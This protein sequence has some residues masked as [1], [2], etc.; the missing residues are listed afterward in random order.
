MATSY[1]ATRHGV[2]FVGTVPVAATDHR[3]PSPTP[4]AV[5]VG[6]AFT[7]PNSLA[8][9]NES[10]YSSSLTILPSLQVYTQQ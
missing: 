6:Q 4:S 5:G 9:L 8:A 2:A 3:D 7:M 10:T 1:G